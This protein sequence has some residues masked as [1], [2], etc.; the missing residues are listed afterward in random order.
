MYWYIVVYDLEDLEQ[1]ANLGKNLGVCDPRLRGWTSAAAGRVRARAHRMQHGELMCRGTSCVPEVC[2]QLP[3]MKVLLGSFHV[4]EEDAYVCG[5]RTVF[6]RPLPPRTQPL[7]RLPARTSAPI[8]RPP[9]DSRSRQTPCP[10]PTSCS[11]LSN[12]CASRADTSAFA[13]AGYGWLGLLA[14]GSCTSG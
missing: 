8:T 1:L 2:M 14:P 3:Q 9:F 13:S 12:G 4:L 7:S 6:K 11:I 5:A 10:P